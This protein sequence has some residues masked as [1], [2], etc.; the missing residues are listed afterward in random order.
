MSNYNDGGAAYDSMGRIH[1]D[2]IYNGSKT[3]S[4]L[5]DSAG[6]FSVATSYLSAACA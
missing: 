5:M 2:H 6:L 1:H 4:L 3:M